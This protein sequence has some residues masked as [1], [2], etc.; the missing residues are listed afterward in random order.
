MSPTRYAL[1][2]TILA[3]PI[4]VF[5]QQ[6][7]ACAVDVLGLDQA[8]AMALDRNRQLRVAAL[9]V[10]RAQQ[11]V[12]EARTRQ[13]FSTYLLAAELTLRVR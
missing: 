13:S 10:E 11:R 3:V 12:A 2:A 6:R 9:D 7:E 1:L 4:R 5:T 8:V